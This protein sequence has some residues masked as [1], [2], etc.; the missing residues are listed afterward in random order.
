MTRTEFNPA[1]LGVFVVGA[2]LLAVVAIFLWGP[3]SELWQTKYV[4]FFDETATGLDPGSVVRLNGVTIGKVDLINLYWDPIQTNKVYTGVVVQLDPAKVKRISKGGKGFEALVGHKEISARLGISGLVSFSL[5]VD[6][7]VEPEPL[8]TNEYHAWHRANYAAYYGQYEW[9][10]ARQSTIA[11]MMEKLEDVL[12]NE[13]IPNLIETLGS[14]FS[15]NNTNGLLYK[16]SSGLDNFNALATTLHTTL[17]NNTNDFKTV[18]SNFAVMSSNTVPKL[19]LALSNFNAA[20]LSAE[21]NLNKFGEGV[22]FITNNLP[23][24]LS[25]LKTNLDALSAEVSVFV[26]GAAPL[27][28]QAVA[29]LRSLQDAIE[30]LQ[31]LIEYVERHPDSL[32]RGRAPEK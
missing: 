32:L 9:I 8:T 3:F 16:T 19:D 21:N 20:C 24:V 30:S 17:I 25:N 28:P 22:Q 26:H 6:L 29:T 23:G 12:N 18:V 31:R 14:Q 7:K 10:P 1:K 4:I 11:K 15:T 2:L 27:P 13:G 5:E